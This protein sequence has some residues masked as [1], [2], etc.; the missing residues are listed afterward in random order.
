MHFDDH[1]NYIAPKSQDCMHNTRIRPSV[2]ISIK[3]EPHLFDKFSSIVPHS[4]RQDSHLSQKL[5]ATR[6]QN[7]HVTISMTNR[8]DVEYFEIITL[9]RI[10]SII[11]ARTHCQNSIEYFILAISS[12]NEM[13][14]KNAL[15]SFRYP[16]LLLLPLFHKQFA[17]TKSVFDNIK[18]VQIVL[19]FIPRNGSA[20]PQI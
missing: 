8:F 19:L 16:S 4:Y 18:R 6:P 1:Q 14:P 5:H 11:L 9:L 12:K 3:S 7:L 20:T 15:H 13:A 10:M 2:I 17:I